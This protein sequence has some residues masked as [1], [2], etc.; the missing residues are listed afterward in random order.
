VFESEALRR[1]FAPKTKKVAG[2]W[3][4]FI[5][6]LRSSMVFLLVAFNMIVKSKKLGWAGYVTC[7]SE[8]R[9]AYKIEIGKSEMKKCFGKLRFKR[10]DHI[11]MD[12][13]KQCGM[14]YTGLIWLRIRSTARPF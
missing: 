3:R 9:N 8:M 6:L 14:L 13:K 1:I 4:K 12:L 7:M 10:K 5:D 2:G 11:K